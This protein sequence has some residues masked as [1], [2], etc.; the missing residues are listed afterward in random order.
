M[1]GRVRAKR[2]VFEDVGGA[3]PGSKPHGRAEYSERLR[4]QGDR[5]SS[6]GEEAQSV[7]SAP[8]RTSRGGPSA[9]G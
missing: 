3:F 9:A 7:W 1:T 5:T 6:V 4:Q 8:R 2:G